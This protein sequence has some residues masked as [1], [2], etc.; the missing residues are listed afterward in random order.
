MLHMIVRVMLVV[1][2]FVVMILGIHGLVVYLNRF[3]IMFGRDPFKLFFAIEMPGVLDSWVE[4]MSIKGLLSWGIPVVFI[5]IAILLWYAQSKVP[6][7]Q[8]K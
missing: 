6:S 4:W 2:G 5:V 7:P 1:A 8:S 3:D